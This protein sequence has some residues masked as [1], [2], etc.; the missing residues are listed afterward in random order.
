[1]KKRA[2]ASFFRMSFKASA[3]T[4]SSLYASSFSLSCNCCEIS[5]V[6]ADVG[7]G[8]VRKI[9]RKVQ[10]NNLEGKPCL[11]GFGKQ[12]SGG[13]CGRVIDEHPY[14][15]KGSK[16]AYQA[17]PTADGGLFLRVDMP[18]IAKG[19]ASVNGLG[20]DIRFFGKARKVMEVDDDEDH[21]HEYMGNVSLLPMTIVQGQVDVELMDGVPLA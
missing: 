11:N 20:G 5:K 13:S 16:E 21:K 14:V 9:F 4:P 12:L 3:V 10:V 8:V 18:G 19:D 6:K 2:F 17:K 7:D 15:T 1:M